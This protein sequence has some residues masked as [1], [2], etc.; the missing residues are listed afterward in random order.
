MLNV[1]IRGSLEGKCAK[2]N[3]TYLEYHF[4]TSDMMDRY[5]FFPVKSLAPMTVKEV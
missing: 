4:L 1:F 5:C 3:L 2:V